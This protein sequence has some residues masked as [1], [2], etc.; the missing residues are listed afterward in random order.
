MSRLDLT[1][2]HWWLWKVLELRVIMK[3]GE[4]RGIGSEEARQDGSWQRMWNGKFIQQ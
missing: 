3:E 1:R 2:G 4:E